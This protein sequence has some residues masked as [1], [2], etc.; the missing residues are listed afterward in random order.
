LIL[1]TVGLYAVTAYSTAHRKREIGIRVALGATPAQVLR[2]IMSQGFMLSVVGILLGAAMAFASSRLLAVLL[3]GVSPRDPATLAA[4]AASLMAVAVV[5]CWIPA[6]R[7]L[8]VDPTT[9]LRYE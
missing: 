7:A 3:Y 6:R 9:A 5:A 1:A 8:R 2:L 4:V